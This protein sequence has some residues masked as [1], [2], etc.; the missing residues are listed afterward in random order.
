MQ[1]GS[2]EKMDLAQDKK[3]EHSQ[4][5]AGENLELSPESPDSSL[6]DIEDSSRGQSEVVHPIED[7]Y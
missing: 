2:E 5:D 1:N 3:P 6:Q 7:S 4:A